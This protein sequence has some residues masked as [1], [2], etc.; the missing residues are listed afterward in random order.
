[1]ETGRNRCENQLS[2]SFAREVK[3]RVNDYFEQNLLSRHA[4]G[5]MITKAVVLVA[6][7]FG[8][9]GLVISGLLPLPWM[10]FSCLVMGIGLAGIGFSVTHDALHG[11]YSAN[12]RVNRLIG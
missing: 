11:A 5:A 2:Q 9:Y 10:W 4:N 1:M 8:S 3:A 12:P 7:Y 6:L